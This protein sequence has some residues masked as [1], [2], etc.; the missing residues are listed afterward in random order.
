MLGALLSGC[1][2]EPSKASK[3]KKSRQHL[4]NTLTVTPQNSFIERRFN[5]T[6]SAP[7][8]IRISNQIAGT[9]IEIPYREGTRVKKGDVLV[10]LDDSLTRAEYEKAIASHEQAQLNYDRTL[11]LV[12]RK[13]ASDEE[14][15]AART[16]LKLAKAELTLKKIQLQR[17]TI[18]APF[19]GVISQ[20]LYEPGDTVSINT[21]ILTLVD[22]SHFIIKSAVPESYLGYVRQG[23]DVEIKVPALDYVFDA[24]VTTIFPTVDSTTQQ[25]DIEASTHQTG[26]QLYPGLFAEMII[27]QKIENAILVPV[28]AVQYDNK[29]I[30]VYTLDKNNKAKVRLVKTGVNINE[31]IEIKE[32][33]SDGDIVITRGFV[34]L[35]PGKQVSVANTIADTS[36]TPD[37]VK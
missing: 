24:K 9:L 29:G 16:E 28:N 27:K 31:K 36:K 21:H 1:D 15:S 26:W 6:I 7:N 34:G 4:V 13:L 33:L 35:R 22:T 17:S 12:P 10:H 37:T 18:K 32:G 23:M 5:A 3:S 25:I 20:R 19:D 2:E 8:T 14:I 11:K 30:W